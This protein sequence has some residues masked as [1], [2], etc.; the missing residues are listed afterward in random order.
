MSRFLHLCLL[1]GYGI[2][3]ILAMSQSPRDTPQA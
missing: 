1:V 2:T 3:S